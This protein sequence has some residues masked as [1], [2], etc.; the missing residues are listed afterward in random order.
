MVIYCVMVWG[1]F[2]Y[3][4]TIFQRIGKAANA[5]TTRSGYVALINCLQGAWIVAAYICCRFTVHKKA[6]AL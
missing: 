6:I 2:P 4:E 1:A 3:L 5:Y